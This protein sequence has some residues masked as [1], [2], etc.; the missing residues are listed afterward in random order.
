MESNFSGKASNSSYRSKYL[1]VYSDQLPSV[2]RQSSPRRTHR[3]DERGDQRGLIRCP[4]HQPIH[5]EEEEED[6]DRHSK[7]LHHVHAHVIRWEEPVDQLASPAHSL[8]SSESSAEVPPR[9][10]WAGGWWCTE[11]RTDT[12]RWRSEVEKRAKKYHADAEI[13][14]L[15]IQIVEKATTRQEKKRKEENTNRSDQQST[16]G[17][18]KR[19]RDGNLQVTCPQETHIQRKLRWEPVR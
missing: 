14:A 1:S 2:L 8:G 18:I 16:V 19:N 6:Q 15:P 10:A 17:I 9:T 13:A 11:D 4:E 3:E 7:S 12:K 5:R